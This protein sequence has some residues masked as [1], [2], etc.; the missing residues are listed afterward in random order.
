MAGRKTT[1]GYV[2]TR[3]VEHNQVRYE[4]GDAVQFLEG[5][6]AAIEALLECGAIT[7]SGKAE[8]ETAQA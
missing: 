3:A 6:D 7:G 5:E 4:E 1:G 8:P 2:A